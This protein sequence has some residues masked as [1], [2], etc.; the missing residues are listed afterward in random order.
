MTSLFWIMG[1]ITCG[2][3]QAHGLPSVHIALLLHHGVI[4]V[5]Q[6]SPGCWISTNL[7]ASAKTWLRNV[8]FGTAA[9]IAAAICL[10]SF[11]WA[12]HEART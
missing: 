10:E 2:L 3:C 4:C 9:R 7:A 11:F 6:S 1:M 5:P 8:S 12:P